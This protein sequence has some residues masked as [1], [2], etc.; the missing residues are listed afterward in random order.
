MVTTQKYIRK[1]L[2]VDAVQVTADNLYEI[3]QWC[4]GTVK[5]YNDN[6]LHDSDAGNVA[7][8]RYIAV[9]V[10]NPKNA[11]QTKAFVDDWI[12]YTERG[13]KVYMGKAFKS[14][15]EPVVPAPTQRMG[16]QGSAVQAEEKPAA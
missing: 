12:L 10:H 7:K 2:Y 11:R 3:A 4:Q 13:Y 14:S 16:Q 1:P 15:F 6:T 8:E 9:R 5:D